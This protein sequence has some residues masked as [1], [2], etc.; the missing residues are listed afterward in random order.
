MR[1]PLAAGLAASVLA[2]VVAAPAGAKVVPQKSIAGV[3]LGLTPQQVAKLKGKPTSTRY[4]RNEI[5]G[6]VRIDR[7]GSL[8]V[9]YGGDTADATSIDIETTSRRERT[10]N[11]IGVGSTRKTLRAKVKGVTCE[12]RLCSI[13]AFE[14]GRTVT[15]FRIDSR[16]RVS[17][18]SIGIVVD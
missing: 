4:V 15:T 17:S 11:G 2:V 3:T 18:I 9:M 10:A 14:P 7:F 12:G 8:T 16:A 6:R 5:I 13:G 1:V